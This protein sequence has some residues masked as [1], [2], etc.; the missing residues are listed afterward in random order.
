MPFVNDADV[1]IHLPVDTLKVEEVPDDRER[2]YEDAERIIRGYLAG[3]FEPATLTAW[4]TPATTPDQIRAI[5]G[6]FT[7]AG[8]YRLRFGQSNMDDPA[9][10]KVKYDEA[11]GMLMGV[12]NG[13]ITLIDPGTDLPITDVGLSMDTTYF[14]PTDESTAP[15]FTMDGRF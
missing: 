13:D 11:M 5:A 8:I 4:A 10:A 14:R 2:A 9:Y 12:V 3:V 7:A 1:Q 15:F 6:R